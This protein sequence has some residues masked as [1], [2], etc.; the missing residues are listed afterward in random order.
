[1]HCWVFS[2]I[3]VFYQLDASCNKQKNKYL[4]ISPNVPWEG[5]DHP[6][7]RTTDLG[8]KEKKGSPVPF[9]REQGFPGD[10]DGK[11]SACN[12]GD[13]GSIPESGRSPGEGISYPL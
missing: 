11:E 2:Y 1:M 7:V 9:Y 4:Q 5:Q 10:S 6:C 12:M 13:P 8:G 3:L